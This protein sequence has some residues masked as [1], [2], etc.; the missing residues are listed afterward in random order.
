[1]KVSDITKEAIKEDLFESV[2]EGYNFS[3]RNS[4]ILE[5]GSVRIRIFAHIVNPNIA[6]KKERDVTPEEFRDFIHKLD[7]EL[8]K[9]I[10]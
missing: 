1:M 6:W 5:D 7:A 9:E 8:Q 2:A 3:N 4:L 10:K